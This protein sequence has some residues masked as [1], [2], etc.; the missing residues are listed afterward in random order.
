M[1]NKS[2]VA[3]LFAV[4]AGCSDSSS[5]ITTAA[6]QQAVTANEAQV[7]STFLQG[8][9]SIHRRE[10]PHT[11]SNG[12]LTMAAKAQSSIDTLINFSGSFTAAGF[13]GDGNPQSV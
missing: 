2:I 13:D 6:R 4:A 1:G 9:R 11:V 3:L 7:P 5:A 10:A 8:A 12:G